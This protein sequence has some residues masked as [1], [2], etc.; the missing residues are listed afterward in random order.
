MGQS[1]EELNTQIAGTRDHLAADLDAL[2]DKVSPSAIVE[3]RK[4]AARGRV[5]DLKSKVMGTAG[6][7]GDSAPDVKGAAQGVASRTGDTIEGS[8]IAAGLVAFGAGVVLAGLLPTSAKEAR[9]ASQLVDTA[10]EQAQPLIA[11]AKAAGQD[12]GDSLKETAGQAVDEVRS[13]A[14][15][16][17][18]TV[19]QEG[20]SSAEAVRSEAQG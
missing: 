12:I 7:V 2:Q 10:K 1:T 20:T 3:R 13:T 6:G 11:D 8:P 4:A 17:A 19:K 9:V 18:E 5:S 15:D 16:S 14:Q